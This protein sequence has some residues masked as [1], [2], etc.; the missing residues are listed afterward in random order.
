MYKFRWGLV[1]H[2]TAMVFVIGDQGPYVGRMHVH[3]HR[4]H[5]LNSGMV[6]GLQARF[7]Y[8]VAG[9]H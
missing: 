9:G 7:G 8:S 2:L 6:S 1:V 5:N 4:R 3:R